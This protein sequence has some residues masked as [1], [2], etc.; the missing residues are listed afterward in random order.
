M[1]KKPSVIHALFTSLTKAI[2]KENPHHEEV[3]QLWHDCKTELEKNIMW[4]EKMRTFLSAS[5]PSDYEELQMDYQKC[6]V[7]LQIM[8]SH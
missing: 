4:L 2:E 8:R 3:F 1:I 5:I 6:L 7:R